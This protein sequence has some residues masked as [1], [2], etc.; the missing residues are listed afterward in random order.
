ME[1]LG[2]AP[3][4]AEEKQEPAEEKEPSF[5]LTFTAADM[6]NF[7]V[8]VAGTVIGGTLLVMVVAIALGAARLVHHT[9]H[10]TVPAANLAVL[11]L[12]TA[13]AA[14]FLTTTTLIHKRRRWLVWRV[15]YNLI[16]W[17][18]FGAVCVLTWLGLAAGVK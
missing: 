5:W 17:G 4:K 6:R 11:G 7:V 18:A 13:I 14:F 16:G 12:A 2:G 15:T 3:A 1:Q 9:R 8:T 10:G